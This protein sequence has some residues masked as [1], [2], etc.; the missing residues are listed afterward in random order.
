MMGLIARG[1]A[2]IV[3]VAAAF[4]PA[5]ADPFDGGDA[6]AGRRL[7]WEGIGAD[8]QPIR[9]V[10]QGDIAVSGAQFSCLNCHRPSGQGSTEGGNYVPAITAPILFQPRHL[11]RNRL[12]KELYQEAQPETFWARV[13]Q[14]RLRPGYDGTT[15]ARVLREGVD[16]SGA[17]IHPIMPRY[18]LP[19]QD[20]RNLLAFLRGLGDRIDAGVEAQDIHFATVVTANADP[21]ARKAV[22]D[23]IQ[24][25]F[26]WMNK[27]TKGDTSRPAF[28]PNFR[29]NFLGAYR[30]WRLHVWELEGPPASWPAQLDRL[31]A[32]QPVFAVVSGLVEGPWAPI[33]DFCDAQRLPCLFP[34][35]ELPR[36]ADARYGYSLYFN[37][38][39]ELEGEAALMHLADTAPPA[40]ILQLRAP[41]PAGETPADALAA[42]AALRLPQTAVA[43]REVAD[44]ALGEVLGALALDAEAP[45]VIVLWPDDPAA[46]VA[47]L[48]ALP[49]EGPPIYLPS[50]VL[51]EAMGNLPEA[52]DAR[53]RFVWPY[54][55]PDAYHPR[56]FRVRAW[57]HTR[58][59]AVTH[60]RLQRQ[61]YFALTLLEVGLMHALEDFYR[62]YLIELIEHEAENELNPGTHPSLALGPGQ[63]FASKGAYIAALAPAEKR[64][65]RVVSDW[66]VP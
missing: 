41:G 53:L 51:P 23:T 32:R 28:S 62:D 55:R 24:V 42:L 43:T 13:R 37:R 16:S 26:D 45:D 54:E 7:Y 63:R 4:G 18:D 33:G 40:R 64:G 11:D 35:T 15:L 8:G 50:A 30:Y 1:L 65:Y 46:A 3:M 31:Y 59:L 21:A 14:P 20:V 57:M 25:Y 61:T 52:L 49:L 29:S 19:D 22:I 38:G 56:K 39:L 44:A 9:G 36:T 10:T 47:A 27:D 5:L 48:A 60:D 12:F 34:N 58:R 6:A 66:L 2:V 17:P